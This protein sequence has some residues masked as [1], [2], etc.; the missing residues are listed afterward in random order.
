M[1]KTTPK[2]ITVDAPW[3]MARNGNVVIP[4]PK[5]IYVPA[6]I[7]LSSCA[8]GGAK[9]EDALR[10]A[11]LIRSAPELLAILEDLV[12]AIWDGRLEA[13]GAE[14]FTDPARRVINEIDPQ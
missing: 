11:R 10:N 13:S 6:E 9:Y 7:E 8:H 3:K 1:K 2:P 4:D 14:Y 5:G 12:E